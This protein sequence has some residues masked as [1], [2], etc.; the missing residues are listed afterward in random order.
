[1]EKADTDE[2]FDALC[3]TAE[4]YDEA[5]SKMSPPLDAGD[6]L[7]PRTKES[8]C[9]L[10][11]TRAEEELSKDSGLNP[12]KVLGHVKSIGQ[13]LPPGGLGDAAGGKLQEVA[14]QTSQKVGESHDTALSEGQD[15]KVQALQKFAESFDAAV[16]AATGE[17]ELSKKLS[18]AAAAA[19]EK[20]AAEKAAGG[21]AGALDADA[22]AAVAEKLD[23]VDAEL[24][25]ET[26][27]NPNAVL[28]GLI[29]IVALW[30]PVASSTEL[31]DRLANSFGMLKQRMATAFTESAADDNEAKL[32][33]L[34]NFARKV[35]EIQEKLGSCCPEFCSAVVS[36]GASQDL[37]DAKKELEK[38]KGM[39]PAVV[40]KNL[41]N[42]K[43]Y[44]AELDSAELK[45]QLFEI[46]EN[47]R[48]RITSSYTDNPEK[49]AGLLNFAG[50]FDA[51]IDGLDGAGEAN[52]KAQLE[53]S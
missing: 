5:H 25:Q 10:N 49:R 41:R 45:A 42:L 19:A 16:T 20:A 29:S 8:V 47:M 28:K 13:F 43:L 52:L 48:S 12:A 31:K 7:L 37:L 4:S 14:S 23:A 15:A 18:E 9:L 1:V 27:M 33:A 2:A 34:V 24:S 22:V 38:D 53:A 32:K 6:A 35:D 40:L 36:T 51:A 21:Y 39:N 17:S 50:S 30:E 11:L 46:C 3:K 26:G 44:W